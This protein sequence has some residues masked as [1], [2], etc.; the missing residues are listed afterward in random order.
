MK[1]SKFKIDISIG[2]IDWSATQSYLRFQALHSSIWIIPVVCV[3]MSLSMFSIL[4]VAYLHAI[5]AKKKPKTEKKNMT[6]E[7]HEALFNQLYYTSDK[8]H[9][10]ESVTSLE[11]QESSCGTSL[12]SISLEVENALHEKYALIPAEYVEDGI[13]TARRMSMERR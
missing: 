11:D 6:D 5:R 3:T 8:I 13:E 2:C 12:R 9:T 1:A 4:F 7:L 10:S